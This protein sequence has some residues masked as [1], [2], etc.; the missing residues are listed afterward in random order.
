MIIVHVL[1]PF[2]TGINTFIHELVF[3]MPEYEH[4][5]IHGER[6]ENRNISEIK[7]EY[8]GKATF[9]KWENAQ[10]EISIY[11]DYKAFRELKRILKDIEFDILHLHSSKAGFLGRLI[12]FFYGFKEVVYTPNAVS[13]MRT[14][15]SNIKRK[16][17]IWI[18]K[19]ANKVKTIIVSSSQ[20]E[21]DE[22]KKIGINS[23]IIP[24][25]VNLPQKET[26]TLKIDKVFHIVFCAKITTQKNPTLFNDIALNYKDDPKIKFTW[27]G[28]GDEK[29]LLTSDNITVTDWKSKKDVYALLDEADLY[30][31]T[32]SWEGLSLSTLEALA[33]A[34]PVVLSDCNGNTD[35]INSK[36]YGFL[37][38]TKEEAIESI[39]T[40]RKDGE[41]FT[42]MSANSLKNYSE[43]YNNYKC[44]LRYKKLY[45]SL[46]KSK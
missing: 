34:L 43:N 32:S 11:K 23:I 36:D 13:F 46:K 9:I 16:I 41:L 27:I 44:G 18:E 15:I 35:V 8:K 20:S 42:K 25:G 38:S 2:A 6:K 14:D 45:N 29:N 12:C 10:R 39:N 3:S 1:E 31:S 26:K 5:I 24:N 37:F 7:K 33:F 22:F 30:L 40:L 4:I 28:G 19:V 21:F 17:Y